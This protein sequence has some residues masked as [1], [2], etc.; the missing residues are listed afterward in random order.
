MLIC[1]RYV[2]YIVWL[3]DGAILV[4]LFFSLLCTCSS[5]GWQ[6]MCTTWYLVIC[7][8]LDLCDW[9]CVFVCVDTFWLSVKNIHSIAQL[10]RWLN[11]H[12]IQQYQPVNRIPIILMGNIPSSHWQDLL[13]R[14]LRSFLVQMQSETNGCSTL[15][16][17]KQLLNFLPFL[18]YFFVCT[19]NPKQ[20]SFFSG[21]VFFVMLFCKVSSGR[22]ERTSWANWNEHYR[23]LFEST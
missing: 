15:L 16:V 13:S 3:I 14:G 5:C 6:W 2:R 22:M 18:W 21:L 9:V 19:S 1:N 17:P 10:A 11:K 20:S 7:A 8:K 4:S 12:L 23:A